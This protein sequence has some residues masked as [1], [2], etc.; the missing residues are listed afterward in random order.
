MTIKKT[1]QGAWKISA[2]ING[3]LVTRQYFGYTR[4]VKVPENEVENYAKLCN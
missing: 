3:Y 4:N 1:F 2:I